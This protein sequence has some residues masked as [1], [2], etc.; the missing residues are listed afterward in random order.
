[1]TEVETAPI[2]FFSAKRYELDSFERA[3]VVHGFDLMPIDVRLDIDTATLAAGAPVVSIFV[4]DDASAPV[5]EKLAAG[6]TRC[7]ALRCA[8]FNNVDLAAAAS[9][10][11]RVV[12]VPAY[13]PNAVAEHTLAMILALNRKIHRAYNRVRDGNFALDGLVGFDLAGKTAGVV[14]TGRIGAIVARLLWH[15][16]CEVIAADVVR[17]AHLVDLGVRYVD[18]D[19]LIEESQV[20]SL[21]CP[22]KV[23]SLIII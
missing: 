21:N 8:G 4:N 23:E 14:G 13:S 19:R 22:L 10:G 2:R 1:V 9:H 15:L 3:N 20:I 12:R 18:L 5:I 16:R 11:I 7:L 17:D 6:G